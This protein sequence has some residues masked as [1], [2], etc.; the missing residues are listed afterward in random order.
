M[1]EISSYIAALPH[2]PD[3]LTLARF[4]LDYQH[5]FKPI[6]YGIPCLI[7]DKTGRQLSIEQLREDTQRLAGTLHHVYHIGENDVVMIFSPNHVDYPTVLWATFK[8]GGIVSCSNPQFTAAE[9][10]NQLMTSKASFVIGHSS[11]IDTALS[12]AHLAGLSS[13]RVILLDERSPRKGNLVMPSVQELIHESQYQAFPFQERMLEPGEGKTKVALLSWSSGTTGKPK[14]VAIS[15]HALIANVIQMA[16]HNQVGKAYS[17]RG[18]RSFRPGD[19]AIGVL[20]FYHVA[21]LVIGLHFALFCAMSVVVVEKYNILNTL[22]SI[23]RHRITHLIVVPP[24]AIDLCKH[25]AVGSHDLSLV[26]Y[27]MIGAAP[28]SREIQ[29]QL[30]DVFPDAQIGQA[31][32]LTEMTTTLAMIEGTQK[33]SPL[34]SGGRLLPGVEARVIKPDGSLAQCGEQGELI[35]KGPAAALGYLND[36]QATKETFVNGWI[37]TGDQVSISES[38]E[39]FVV[40]RLKE[41]LKVRGFQVAPAEIEGCLLAHP[42]ITDCCV[43]GIPDEYSGELPFAYIVLSPDAHERTAFDV[44]AE[45]ELKLSIVKYIADRKVSYKQLKGGV[46]VVDQIPKNGSG[47]LLRRL[48]RK[49]AKEH[50]KLR[51]RL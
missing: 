28:L 26:K 36:D 6:R 23:V 47:K 16:V 30:Y 34:G 15:H 35:V 2:I 24:Q 44:S 11:N 4:M 27:V 32:G 48:L 50:S 42:D 37:R 13:D 31:Y 5:P 22:E 12:A 21:G 38:N 19:V 7:E 41:L 8:L 46:Q 49:R 10:S 40:D 14:A 1:T 43:I 18:S 17:P 3:D 33:R 29:F 39:V 25:P 9:L 51:A 20:P 45:T